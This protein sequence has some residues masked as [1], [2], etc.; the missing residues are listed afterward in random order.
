M[1]YLLTISILFLSLCSSSQ[2]FET[3]FDKGSYI[4][5]HTQSVHSTESNN[6]FVRSEKGIAL[7]CGKTGYISYNNTTDVFD[8]LDDVMT[9]GSA[10]SG[11]VWF[12]IDEED[13]VQHII[14][15]TNRGGDRYVLGIH[16]N[17]N[18]R[19]SELGGDA[20][21]GFSLKGDTWY[22]I[23]F[24]QSASNVLSLYLN[25][26]ELTD[27]NANTLHYANEFLSICSGT[28]GGSPLQGIIAKVAIYDYVLT[29]TDRSRLYESF[30]GAQLPAAEKYPRYGNWSKPT[31]INEDG[32]V[33]AYN[34]IP[35]PDGYL[36]DISGNGHTNAIAFTGSGISGNQSGMYFV[37]GTGLAL[38]GI[39]FGANWVDDIDTIYTICI[40]A[41]TTEDDV[42]IGD[43]SSSD[44]V[45]PASVSSMRHR[46]GG[47]TLVTYTLPVNTIN[48]S[49]FFDVVISRNG[50]TSYA[51][52]NGI[53]AT[54]NPK[55]TAGSE[56]FV[57]SWIGGY[58]GLPL[59]GV[60][61]DIKIYDY[62]FTEQQAINYHNEFAKRPVLVETF[63]YDP[64]GDNVPQGW[65][66]GTG[67]YIIKELTSDDA[68]LSDLTTG[69][70]YLECTSAGTIGFPI[71]RTVYGTVEFYWNKSEDGLPLTHFYNTRVD[72]SG[73]GILFRANN[74]EILGLY[75]VD[76]GSLTAKFY[77]GSFYA[78]TETW[79]KIK[80]TSTAD[81]ERYAYIK[82]GSFGNSYV[83]MDD[84]G[85]GSNPFTDNTNATGGYFVLDYDIGDKIGPIV[86][87]EGV[88]Q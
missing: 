37:N 85:S 54:D 8:K 34:M 58:G 55:I 83:L 73:D 53:A 15:F 78:D 28:S 49:E 75:Y 16:S 22:H 68:V 35:S 30:V 62:P 12:K 11:E 47:G 61:D 21:S 60:I 29:S 86:T 79:H 7:Y 3:Q 33:A 56:S 48:F 71:Q 1:K 82:G 9:L 36:V 77:S 81:G 87:T 45:Y 59:I 23:V 64:V 65:Q 26:V 84:S 10:F 80:I 24:A 2:I 39:N 51:W 67:T 41:K 63:E 31:L 18:L 66:E 43:G 32:L 17:D 19:F 25:N 70:K 6:T 40:R 4:D 5:K 57:F 74:S 42:I 14:G 69:T 52:V 44:Y 50:T 46:Y 27:N 13:V 38:Q 76:D 20:V 72:G 88:K